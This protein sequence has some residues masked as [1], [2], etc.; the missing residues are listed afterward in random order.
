MKILNLWYQHN[1]AFV[2]HIW[3]SFAAGAN[4]LG[5]TTRYID[6]GTDPQDIDG[7]NV[8]WSMLWQDHML[9]NKKVWQTSLYRG[10]PFIVMDLGALYRYGTYKVAVNGINNDGYFGP[11]FNDDKRA[12]KLDL[13]IREW[14]SNPNGPIVIAAQNSN[15]GQFKFFD[16]QMHWTISIMKNIRL[17]TDRK[18]ILRHHHRHT[19]ELLWTPNN[20]E[21]TECVKEPGTETVLPG[22]DW[23]THDKWK[24][25]VDDAYCIINYCSNPSIQAALMGLP[26]FTT[27]HSLAW[28]VGNL[29]ITNINNPITPDRTQW[30]NDIAYTE[31]YPEEIATGEV[32][33]RLIDRNV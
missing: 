3:E 33:D 28:E 17:H 4:K 32:L 18:I 10:E 20:F 22:T 24:F 29:D 13:H 15:S 16:E 7:I 1:A 11:K 2:R 21:Y 25:D 12:K 30:L 26:L 23:I 19:L 8:I 14:K 27:K 5:Y 9:P 6:K 31:W